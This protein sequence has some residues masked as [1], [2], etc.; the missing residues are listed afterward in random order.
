MI[1]KATIGLFALLLSLIVGEI[2]ARVVLRGSP[3]SGFQDSVGFYRYHLN[4]TKWEGGN[5]LRNLTP[6]PY[7]G[8]VMTQEGTAA[9]NHGFNDP[10]PFPYRKKSED[11]FVIS[12][13]GGSVALGWA[14]WIQNLGK[15]Y[16]VGELKKK[17]PA[18]AKKKIVI[19]DMAMGGY[20][21]P[22]QL[23][24]ASYFLGSVDLFVR[25]R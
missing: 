8:Y 23:N 18:L 15:E 22:Q 19:L 12:V 7:F 16:F 6:H 9:N 1:W 20:K 21:Q 24:I 4:L 25:F 14:G 5:W 17:V 13:L 3:D 10:E 2:A 11:E